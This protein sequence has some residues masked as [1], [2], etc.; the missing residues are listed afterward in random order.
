MGVLRHTWQDMSDEESDRIE[1]ALLAAMDEDDAMTA[2]VVMRDY[3]VPASYYQGAVEDRLTAEEAQTLQ[4]MYERDPVS[5]ASERGRAL[6]AK[7]SRLRGA[8]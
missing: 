2:L 5:H 6:I 1:A 4:R 8:V 3:A 7:L